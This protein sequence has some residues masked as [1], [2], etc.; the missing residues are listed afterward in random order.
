[1]KLVSQAEQML[2][3]TYIYNTILFGGAYTAVKPY[4]SGFTWYEEDNGYCFNELVVNK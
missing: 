2:A 3:D 4:V 1:M